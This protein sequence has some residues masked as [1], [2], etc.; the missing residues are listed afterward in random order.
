MATNV[1]SSTISNNDV[2]GNR[3]GISILNASINF[4]INFTGS[5]LVV[6]HNIVNGNTSGGV[7]LSAGAFPNHTVTVQNNLVSGEWRKWD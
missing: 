1:V 2:S 4:N 3:V 6:S 5:P 7:V